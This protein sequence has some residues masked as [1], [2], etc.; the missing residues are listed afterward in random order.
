MFAGGLAGLLSGLLGVG[1]GFIIVPALK[2]YTDLP[3]KSIVA[4]SLGVL[5][6]VTG[7]GA[8]FS[9]V[10]GTLNISVAAP[11]SIAALAGLLLG[12]LIGKKLSG[13]NIQL[14][15]AI[16]TLIIALSLLGKGSF[17]FYEQH[18]SLQAFF[19]LS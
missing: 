1:G 17:H 8:I 12:Q 19:A 15:F 16:F 4:T 14:I 5:A 11:F 3:V 10:S 2:R 18:S 13:P 9:A 6:L 7:G